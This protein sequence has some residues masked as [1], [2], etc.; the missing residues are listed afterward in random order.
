[1]SWSNRWVGKPDA[2]KRAMDRYSE[3]LTMQSKDE[4]DDA[5]PKLAALLDANTH[6]GVLALDANGHG[7]TD[8]RDGKR[9][10][11]LNVKLGQVGEFVD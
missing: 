4:F 11:T 2:I 6:D 1:M 3:K 7:Y 10:V 9:I 8:S 5:K